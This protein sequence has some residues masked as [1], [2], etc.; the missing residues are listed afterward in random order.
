MTTHT[1]DSAAAKPSITA[2]PSPPTGS[3]RWMTRT[4][5]VAVTAARRTSSGVSSVLSSTKIISASIPCT[6]SPTRRTSSATLGDSL[7]VGTTM[8]NCIRS[9]FRAGRLT[10]ATVPWSHA[11]RIRSWDIGDPIGTLIRL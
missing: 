2:P 4:G 11:S 10:M 7:Y 3:S 6:A 1:S 5:S 8:D 9:C